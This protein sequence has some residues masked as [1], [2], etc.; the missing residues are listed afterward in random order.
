MLR[1]YFVSLGIFLAIDAVWLGLVAPSLYQQAIGHLLVAQPYWPAAAVFYCLFVAGLLFFVTAP[2][3]K[4]KN[5][6]QAVLHGAIFGCVTYA[7]YDLTNM[8]TLPN[9]PLYLTVIDMI[10]GSTV[11]AAT[12]GITTRILK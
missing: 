12:A 5:V 4:A 8:A 1:T 7:T 11:A 3:I 9:W 2:A 6:G 10:W